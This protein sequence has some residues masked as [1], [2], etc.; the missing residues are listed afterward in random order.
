MHHYQDIIAADIDQF[1]LKSEVYYNHISH[2]AREVFNLR[3]LVD[4][5][6]YKSSITQ[7]SS[8]IRNCR[9]LRIDIICNDN[10]VLDFIKPYAKF[11]DDDIGILVDYN[12]DDMED[13]H[14]YGLY[15][16]NYF[17]EKE[18]ALILKI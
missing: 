7:I 10:F 18:T 3:Y 8:K 11:F 13:L 4:L 6:I 2:L 1:L 12:S 15:C 16:E 5:Q 17:G 14:N 9:L